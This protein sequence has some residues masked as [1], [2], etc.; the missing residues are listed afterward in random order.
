ML[1]NAYH[2][3]IAWGSEDPNSRFVSVRLCAGGGKGVLGVIKHH[4][5]GSPPGVKERPQRRRGGGGDERISHFHVSERKEGGPGRR[6][7]KASLKPSHS[8]SF[9]HLCYVS[10]FS[11][12][13]LVVFGRKIP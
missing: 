8:A 1:V 13:C 3:W 6:K 4:N 2:L 7:H 12:S 10:S 11:R 9:C 5:S